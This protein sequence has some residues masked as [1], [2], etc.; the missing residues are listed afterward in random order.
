LF[1]GNGFMDKFFTSN[2]ILG[3]HYKSNTFSL[4]KSIMN[5]FC[6]L[7]GSLAVA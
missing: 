3:L 6:H 2:G 7:F 4:I 1:I 5:F